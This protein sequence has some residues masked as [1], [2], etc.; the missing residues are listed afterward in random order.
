MEL[1]LQDEVATGWEPNFLL[2]TLVLC[3][4]YLRLYK[5]AY[6]EEKARN[7]AYRLAL[8]MKDLKTCTYCEYC[9]ESS[10]RVKFNSKMN[11]KIFYRVKFDVKT[12]F[13]SAGV[14]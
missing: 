1:F 5:F 3:A 13:N 12:K 9:L 8:R 11:T 4:E 7:L 6:S 14:Q 10:L 2:E